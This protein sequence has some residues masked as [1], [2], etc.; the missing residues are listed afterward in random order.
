MDIDGHTVLRSLLVFDISSHRQPYVLDVKGPKIKDLRPN[1]FALSPDGSQLAVLNNE[2]VYVF[3][4]PP[5]Q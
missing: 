5:I 4:L 1:D 2:T 3:A